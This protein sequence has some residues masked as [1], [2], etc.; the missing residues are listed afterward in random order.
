MPDPLVM[1]D[2]PCPLCGSEAHTPVLQTPDW[3]GSVGGEFQIVRC[4]DC[5]H[6]YLNPAPADTSLAA[7]YP[8][9]YGPHQRIVEEASQK[10]SHSTKNAPEP[11]GEPESKPSRASRQPWY[12]SPLVRKIP[13]P[14]AYYRWVTETKSVWIPPGSGEGKR[15]LELGCS[16]GWFL[17][18]L[19]ERGW[20]PVGIDLVAGPL[21]QARAAGFDVHEGT[22]DSVSFDAESFDAAFAWM[23]IEHVPRP[24]ETLQGIHRVV[25]PGG[26]FALSVPNPSSWEPRLF[27]RHWRGY[28]LPRHLQHF[29]PRRLRSLLA[30]E[31]F[32]VEAVIHQ[33]S[34]LFWTGSLGS[35][36][37]LRFPRWPFGETLMGAYEDT[38][39]LACYLA[40]GPL[41]R[42]NA[43]LKQSGRLTIVTRRK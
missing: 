9:D 8:D 42:L 38:P 7:C 16:S 20:S 41:A 26:W 34:F 40:L 28:D 10:G 25:R 14:R 29:T 32:E 21:A 39:P 30:E 24:R 1:H 33:P 35:W 43:L 18:Q 22:L 15:A 2:V 37:R 3:T 5:R 19:Q 23:V 31:G 12:L 6:A 17:A 13:G 4:R 11:R 27:G 36:L